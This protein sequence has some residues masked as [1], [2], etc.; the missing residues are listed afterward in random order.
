MESF[1][2]NQYFETG[3]EPVDRQHHGLV[4]LI[5]RFGDLLIQAE[6]ASVSDMDALFAEL[7]AYAKYHFQEEEELMQKAGLDPR[8]IRQHKKSHADFVQ[9]VTLLHQRMGGLQQTSDSLLKFLTYWLT[10][11]ILGTDQSMAKQIAA[12][13]AGET[14]ADALAAEADLSE[15]AT[16]P[17]LHALNGLFQQVSDR[18]RELNEL[19]R[20]LEEKVA[21]RTRSLSDANQ[22]LE[23]LALTDA[24]T[25]LP[26]RRQAM[27][28]LAQ[29][30]AQSERDSLPLACMMVDADGFKQVNDLHGHAAGDE[31][32][33]QL[34][35]LLRDGVR[36]NDIV[37]R[38]GGDEFLII[39]PGTAP[40]GALRMA[41]AVREKAA[42]LQVQTGSGEWLGSISIGVA[43]KTVP[44]QNI[45][46]L[47]K[48]ADE[49]L[50]CA[51]RNGRNC[52]ANGNM[53]IV[54]AT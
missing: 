16:G 25:G 50:Y 36:R 23:Q 9:D 8:H 18:N 28:C 29:A 13:S 51:K 38:L 52:V 14:P 46:D 12:I 10:Y 44:M 24:L 19:N 40:G 32:L 15:G 5:N 54:A 6:G 43:A 7:A 42:R 21:Q 47:I 30:W 3:L 53:A 33:R 34:S 2:W 22:L 41:E 45:E 1:P 26:N 37:C 11:H 4:D 31:V 48:A 39:C 17:L 49:G 27:A 20:N 35:A